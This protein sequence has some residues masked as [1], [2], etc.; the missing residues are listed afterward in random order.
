LKKEIKVLASRGEFEEKRF[1]E[2]LETWYWSMSSESRELFT[3]R[4]QQPHLTLVS[5][6]HLNQ[7][8]LVNMSVKPRH[9]PLNSYKKIQKLKENFS[10][11]STPV[12]LVKSHKGSSSF[13]LQE[14]RND[15]L[16]GVYP[17]VTTTA[18]LIF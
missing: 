16:V 7:L 11:A 18:Q 13:P 12:T 1:I 4:K 2:R 14:P 9:F 3:L 8:F 17:S 10:R 15:V 5:F 6:S